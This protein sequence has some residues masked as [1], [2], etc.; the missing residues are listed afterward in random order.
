MR[1]QFQQWKII[2]YLTKEVIVEGHY[3]SL[4][5]LGV[6]YDGVIEVKHVPPQSVWTC[7]SFLMWLQYLKV[8]EDQ[9]NRLEDILRKTNIVIN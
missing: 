1:W 7:P 5:K 4:C 6:S 3:T 8:W 2:D 9:K